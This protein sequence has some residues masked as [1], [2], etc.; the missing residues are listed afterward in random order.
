MEN[1]ITKENQF[2]IGKEYFLN[3]FALVFIYATPTLSHLV[4][5]PI[6][7]SEPVRIFLIFTMVHTQ[8]KNAYVLAL[9]L[10]L[11]SFL[12]SSHPIASGYAYNFLSKKN[13]KET[14]ES[15]KIRLSSNYIS[16]YCFAV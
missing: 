10:P 5:F 2:S 6:Y 14:L 1:V 3:L 11:F 8:K 4:S 16:K 12:V 7:Y 9:T 15:M 13:N